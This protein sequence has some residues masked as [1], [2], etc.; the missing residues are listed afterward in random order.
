[1]IEASGGGD[2]VTLGHSG[3][4]SVDFRSR[5]LLGRFLASDVF[6]AGWGGEK[7]EISNS[8]MVRFEQST[9]V[10]TNSSLVKNKSDNSLKASVIG[11]I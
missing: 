3:A 10:R 2:F 7:L 8:E 6:H 9:V 5:S 1:M 11:L 4:L